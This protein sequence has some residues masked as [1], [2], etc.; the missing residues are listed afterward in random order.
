MAFLGAC[1][2]HGWSTMPLAMARPWKHP[3]TG[4]FWLRKRVPDELRPLV[5]KLEVKQSL[6]TRDPTDAKRRHIEA[7]TKLEAQ[8]ENLRR[9]PQA[10]NEREAHVIAAPVCTWYV[11]QHAANPS[12]QTFW[13]T[14]LGD[15]L[16]VDETPAFAP[17][18]DP[19]APLITL[20]PH[21]FRKTGMRT[22]CI[23]QADLLL[24]R[25][26]LQSDAASRDVLARAVGVAMQ[27]AAATLQ[28]YTRG[29]FGQPG[30]LTLSGAAL[31][32]P[33][34]PTTPQLNG[35]VRFGQLT[36]GWIQERQP[37]EKT[38]Y[39]FP[40]IM[41]QFA[42]FLGHD[43]AGRVAAEDVIRWKEAL[44]AEGLRGTTIR[45]GKLAAVRT[46]FQWGV[47]NRRLLG[48][49]AGRVTVSTKA[50]QAERKRSFTD[51]EARLILRAAATEAD[52]VRRWVTWLCAYSGARIAEVCQLRKEDVG[53][54]DGVWCLHITHAA[55]SL[56]TG[57]SE[58]L[59]PL[60]PALI[61][62]G[63]LRFMEAS[64]AGPLFP[65][66]PPD[67]FG[68]RGGNG[69]KVLG[70]WVRGLGITDPRVQPNHAWR[71]R[72][73]TLVRRHGLAENLGAALTGH[74]PKTVGEAYGEHP[75]VALDREIRKLPTIDLGEEIE[76]QLS[77]TAKGA[78]KRRRAALER[79][80]HPAKRPA[81]G[82][83][84]TVD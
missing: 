17:A 10:L 75:V 6:G 18:M 49:P 41:D 40:R 44:L 34:G 1:C 83:R 54:H 43:D 50:K 37:A 12:R 47:D 69:A 72:F 74:A 23:E 64:R 55:G 65:D 58:R 25:E 63:F 53:Q 76:D 35:P 45:N 2:T 9:G 22:W 27:R 15:T 62:A 8:W 73:V 33:M 82:S 84:K 67:R 29:E 7:L 14:S 19:S 5:G 32:Q 26:G 31:G 66:L 13:D 38:R 60:H 30:P 59:V 70:R 48:N 81:A 11:N 36:E 77:P 80:I 52:P 21:Y 28:A 46:I 78:R 20:D 57:S 4:I 61:E 16:W 79:S 68:S 56:K 71:H 3:R 51:A 24:R 42:A 39:V